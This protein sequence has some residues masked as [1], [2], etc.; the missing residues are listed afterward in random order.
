MDLL[1]NISK[2]ENY[3]EEFN[4]IVEIPKGS[5]NKYEI[6]KKTGMIALDRANYTSAPYPFDYG[7][8]PQTLWEDNDP[9]DVILLTT[10]PLN[11]G[12]LVRTRPIAL[13]EM[14]DDGDSDYKIIGVPSKDRRFEEI[15]DLKDLNKHALKEFKHFF[16][17]YKSLKE[18]DAPIEVHG[19]K[20]KTEALEALKKSVV[21][22]EE[23]FG[24]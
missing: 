19:Y 2:G 12:I 16:E 10:F 8:V 21:L 17:T 3:P 20:E 24:K 1:H 22:Y 18:K 14:T 7:F 15:N 13:M 11:S 23:K 9:L 6:D 5:F 4:T